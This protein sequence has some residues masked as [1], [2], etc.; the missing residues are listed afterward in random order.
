MTGNAKILAWG[1]ACS[2][3]LVSPANAD[4]RQAFRR[5]LQFFFDEIGS[6]Y[7]A[8]STKRDAG[9]DLDALRG[10]SIEE[11]ANLESTAD[12]H[13]LLQR[14]TATFGDS[15]FYTHVAEEWVSYLGFES[16]FAQGQVVVTSVGAELSA[17][18]DLQ[19][20]DQIVSFNGRPVAEE[21]SILSAYIGKSSPGAV[22]R[23][24]A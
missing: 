4:K 23:Y 15:H 6:G 21:L 8:L 11:L 13:R 22:Q 17:S 16:D 9:L 2:L 14:I 18:G 24:A 3:L 10:K 20:G 1:V 12:F 7:V 5:D 19:V